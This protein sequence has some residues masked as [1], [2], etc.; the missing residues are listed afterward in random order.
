LAPPPPPHT[1][2][3]GRSIVLNDFKKMGCGKLKIAE[4]GKKL[5]LKACHV[6]TAVPPSRPFPPFLVLSSGTTVPPQTHAVPTFLVN[7]L[8]FFFFSLYLHWTNTYKTA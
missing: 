7:K 6:G 3:P 8:N 1:P 4:L 2:T 5:I